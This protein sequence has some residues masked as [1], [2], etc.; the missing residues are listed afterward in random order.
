MEKMVYTVNETAEI[1]SIGCSK[2]YDLIHEKKLPSI[3]VGRK[4]IIPKKRLE[5]WLNSEQ[6]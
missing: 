2:V 3:K 5:D 1:L 4:F 6:F